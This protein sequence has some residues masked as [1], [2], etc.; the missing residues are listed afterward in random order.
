M[1]LHLYDSLEVEGK[2][3]VGDSLHA[4]Q[5]FLFF[6]LFGWLLASLLACFFSLSFFFFFSYFKL[7]LNGFLRNKPGRQVSVNPSAYRCPH[8][9][10]FIRCTRFFAFS[11]TC[12][13]FSWNCAFSR[14]RA[15]C[16]MR[17]GR[18]KYFFFVFLLSSTEIGTPPPVPAQVT[19]NLFW[20]TCR[21]TYWN[22]GVAKFLRSVEHTW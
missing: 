10:S 22:S 14:S 6:C 21:K 13:F 20:G 9:W 5:A 18:R 16:G 2:G 12:R 17:I 7:A 15:S 19:A 3:R 11:P 8:F 4:L 1:Q